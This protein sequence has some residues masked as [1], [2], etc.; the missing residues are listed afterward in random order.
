MRN[1]VAAIALAADFNIVIQLSPRNTLRPR[2]AGAYEF[3][4]LVYCSN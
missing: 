2:R 4:G 1:A 3:R